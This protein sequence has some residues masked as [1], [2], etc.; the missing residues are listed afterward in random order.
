MD[1][2]GGFEGTA[3]F[4]MDED[5]KGFTGSRPP[6]AQGIHQHVEHIQPP[7]S[8]FAGTGDDLH[9]PISYSTDDG[10]KRR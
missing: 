5:G 6:L 1:S 9:R 8:S 2:D 3:E 10:P 7:V 4:T